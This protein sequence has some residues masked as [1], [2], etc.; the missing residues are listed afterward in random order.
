VAPLDRDDEPVRV[1][2]HAFNTAA[3]C[4]R[5]VVGLKRLNNPR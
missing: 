2:T 3:E 4:E 5:L 1:S